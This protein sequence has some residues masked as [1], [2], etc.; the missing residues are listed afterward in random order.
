MILATA[1]TNGQIP[2]SPLRVTRRR[3]PGVAAPAVRSPSVRLD[4]VD[5]RGFLL[6]AT[7]LIAAGCAR[8]PPP[9]VSGT[10]SATPSAPPLAIGSD[11][12]AAGLLLAELLAGAVAAKGRAAGTGPAGPDWQAS[13]GHGDLAALPGFGT[14]LWTELSQGREAPAAEDLLSE[15][16]GLLEPEVGLLAVPGV[17][18][19]LV[20]LVTEETATA[21][22]ASLTR[23]RGWSKGRRAAVPGPVRSRADGVPGLEAV[24]GAQFSYDVVDDPV[25]RASRLVDGQAAVAAFRRT[26]YLGASGL[27]ALVDPD[28]LSAPEPGVVL[29]AGALSDAEPDTVLAM[30]AVAQAVTTD[31]LVDLQARVAGGGTSSEVAGEWL[32][33]QGLAA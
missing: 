29:V 7:A 12:S 33:E 13:L 2:P 32:R 6:G 10:A 11:G 31:A 18:A 27:V 25:Q 1:L 14:T 26:E 3:P 5:R 9:E 4:G 21:G 8:V 30:D 17:D 15:L 24:Y 19:G 22:I 20:W 23:L 16:A 28:R